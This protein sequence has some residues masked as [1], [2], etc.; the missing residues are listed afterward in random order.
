MRFKDRADLEE[1]SRA[2][3]RYAYLGPNSC[4]A[5][6]LG[7]RTVHANPCD[8]S[9]VPHLAL[10]GFWEPWVTLFLL[11]CAAPGMSFMDIG[12]GFGYYTAAVGKACEPATGTKRPLL[13]CVDCCPINLG[14]T[15]ET[16]IVNGLTHAEMHHLAA[17]R[18]AGIMAVVRLPGTMGATWARRMRGG[19]MEQRKVG[20]SGPETVLGKRM[21]S[22][23]GCQGQ[24][25]LLKIDAEGSDWDALRGAEGCLKRGCVV[26]LEHCKQLFG[27]KWGDDPDAWESDQLE[28]ARSAGFDLLHVNEEGEAEPVLAATVQAR[29]ERMWNLALLREPGRKAVAA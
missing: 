23:I 24:F 10:D 4:V 13:V 17:T 11:R 16:V 27:A 7:D 25:D 12:S 8:R 5:R 14:L 20:H 26:V 19:E 29:P 18:D 1:K 22:L 15:Q 28:W 3:A 21:D 9:M 6:I 2:A